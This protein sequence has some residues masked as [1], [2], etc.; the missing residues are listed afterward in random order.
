MET[1]G[2]LHIVLMRTILY[3]ESYLDRKSLIG[4]E[5][6]ILAL[7]DGMP[8]SEKL[9]GFRDVVLSPVCWRF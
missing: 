9:G 1:N 2:S 5:D 3:D 4:S 7:S 8:V 6:R